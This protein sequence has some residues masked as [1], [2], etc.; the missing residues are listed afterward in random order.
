MS[1]AFVVKKLRDQLVRAEAAIEVAMHENA[2][3]LSG[4]FEAKRDLNMAS[5]VAAKQTAEL[6]QLIEGLGSAH[7]QLA[8]IHNGLAAIAKRRGIMPKASGAWKSDE[9]SIAPEDQPML[10][11]VV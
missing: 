2:Q 11:R 4:I 7:H 5:P 1:D 10:Q 9:A 6:A 8:E 3:L